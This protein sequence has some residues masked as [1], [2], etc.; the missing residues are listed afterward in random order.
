M[1]QVIQD[2]LAP[3]LPLPGVVAWGARLADRSVLSHCYS[4]WFTAPQVEEALGR[5]TLAAESLSQHG[6][7]P[8]RLCWVFEH[9]RIQLARRGDG[10][11]VAIFVENRPSLNTELLENLLNDFAALPVE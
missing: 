11:C 6:I 2:F 4:D 7:Q 5:L 10:S 8:I 9:A 3:R 1:K